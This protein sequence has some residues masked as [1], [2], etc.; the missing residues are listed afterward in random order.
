MNF[1][2]LLLAVVF[3]GIYQWSIA[4][5]CAGGGGGASSV[6][7]NF[8]QGVLL[9]NQLEFNLNYQHTYTNRFKVIDQEI[10]ISDY[11]EAAF[12][13]YLEGVTTN[14]LYARLAYGLSDKLTFSLEAGYYI[15]K[16]EFKEDYLVDTATSR[17]ISDITLFPRYNVYLKKTAL[18]QTEVTLGMGMK[19]PVGEFHDSMSIGR[20]ALTGE[21][22]FEKKSLAIQPS[23]G[24]NDFLF[25][26]FISRKFIPQ[27]LSL[28]LSSLYIIK[29]WNPD[30]D[31]FGDYFSVSAFTTKPIF[32]S[33]ITVV[34]FKQEYMAQKEKLP[35]LQSPSSSADMAANSGGF[36]TFFVPRIIFNYKNNVTLYSLI[37]I[38]LYQYCYGTQLASQVNFSIG[39]TLRTIPKAVIEEPAKE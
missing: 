18:H 32:P 20:D 10:S 3:L 11:H 14:F 27:N 26:A 39:L 22:Y 15:N 35:G 4:Q 30:G 5:C 28:Y 31:K 23:S 25:Y 17:G 34:Q 12:N 7:G 9:K 24:A 36:K 38:P 6:A 29:G 33:F 19:I 21:E 37:E 8:S 1:R 13:N 16:T 2:S